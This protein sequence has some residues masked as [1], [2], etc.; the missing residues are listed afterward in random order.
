[1]ISNIKRYIIFLFINFFIWH[2]SI[3]NG[4]HL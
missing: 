1:M 4:C 3:F 2:I